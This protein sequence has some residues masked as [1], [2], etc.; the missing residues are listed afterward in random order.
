[1]AFVPQARIVH[2]GGEAARKGPRHVAWF[3]RSAWRFFAT[4]GW[5][6]A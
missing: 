5:R 2:H 3:V 1:V 6:F 4:H